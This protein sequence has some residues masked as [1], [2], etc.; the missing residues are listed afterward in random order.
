MPPKIINFEFATVLDRGTLEKEG[1]GF[2]GWIM[3]NPDGSPGIL[4]YRNN[5]HGSDG[6]IP[7][8]VT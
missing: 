7:C 1:Y 2:E 5:W 8:F 4:Y 6:K 3:R